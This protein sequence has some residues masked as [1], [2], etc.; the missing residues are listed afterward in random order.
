[1]CCQIFN[2]SWNFTKATPNRPNRTVSLNGSARKSRIPATPGDLL[3]TSPDHP[4]DHLQIT[5]RSP[6]TPLLSFSCLSLSH[7]PLSCLLH[8]LLSR[9][10]TSQ[11]PSQVNLSKSG[12]IVDWPAMHLP[13]EWFVEVLQPPKRPEAAVL[14][15][16][17]SQH[18]P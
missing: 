5:S 7:F 8:R 12:I 18:F 15:R 6:S 16:G 10:L 14:H 2:H 3:F 11:P 1:M 17:N 4:P 13:G 9:Q